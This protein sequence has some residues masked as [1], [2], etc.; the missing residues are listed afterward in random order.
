VRVSIAKIVVTILG[1]VALV[2]ELWYF[3][4][5]ARPVRRDLP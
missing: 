1:A 2:W 4:A 5:P 3:L